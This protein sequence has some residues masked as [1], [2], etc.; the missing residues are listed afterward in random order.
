MRKVYQQFIFLLLL[1]PILLSN[2]IS[3]AYQGLKLG[4][5][6]INPYAGIKVQYDDN[7]FWDTENEKKDIITTLTPGIGLKLPFTGNSLKLDYHADINKF[8]DYTSQNTTNH[9]ASGEIEFN[10]SGITI[11]LHDNFARLFDRPSIEDATRVKRDDNKAGVSLHLQRERLGIQIGYDNFTRNYKSDPVYEQF[12]RKEHVYSL[13]L[14]HQTFSKTKL[15]FEYD[16]GQIRYNESTSSDSDYSQFLVGAIGDLTDNTTSTIKTG[17][18]ARNYK[19]AGA[20][21]FKSGVLYADVIH[22]FSEKNSLKLD[23]LKTANES[24][25][26]TNNFYDVSKISGTFDHYFT[27]KL[28]GFITGLYQLNAYPKEVTVGSDTKKRKDNYYSLGAGLKYYLK[29]WLTSAIQA[30]H[31]VRDS[32]FSLF[33]IKDNLITFNAKAG[34]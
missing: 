29:E 33:D 11:N 4:E 13:M 3:Y 25:Y 18:Q 6:E 34:F 28:L 8:K 22:K 9:F 10:W 32:N 7:V 24:T 17:Y 20:K 1:S 16:F 21:D 26:G 2:S 5:A 14:T 27:P 23:F 19:N 12:D 31:I 15:L 30:E